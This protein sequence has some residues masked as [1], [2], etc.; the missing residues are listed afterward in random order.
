M[1]K[2][3]YEVPWGGVGMKSIICRERENVSRKSSSVLPGL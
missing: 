1:E 3:K 2:G